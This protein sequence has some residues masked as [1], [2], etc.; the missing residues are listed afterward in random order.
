MYIIS[1]DFRSNEY[2]YV[3][4]LTNYKARYKFSLHK[5][6]HTQVMIL[7][8][9]PLNEDA[10]FFITYRS[11]TVNYENTSLIKI[12]KIDLTKFFK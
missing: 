1:E 3:Q 10:H 11:M 8:Q 6:Q 12:A 7:N 5:N 9:Y 4:F 2:D